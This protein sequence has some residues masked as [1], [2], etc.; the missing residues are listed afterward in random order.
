MAAL[1]L[2][3]NNTG[4]RITGSTVYVAPAS[5]NAT[6]ITVAS[7]K[8]NTIN[9]A[10][11][12]ITSGEE[13]ISL[14]SATSVLNL[15]GNVTGRPIF[16][17]AGTINFSSSGNSPLTNPRFNAAAMNQTSGSVSL[18]GSSTSGNWIGYSAGRSANYTI[19]GSGTLNL[20]GSGGAYLGV[21]RSQGANNSTLTVLTGGTVNIGTT[22]DGNLYLNQDNTGATTKLDVQGGNFTIGTGATT[23]ALVFFRAGG[24]ASKTALMTQSGGLATING[25]QFGGASGTY[26]ATALAT[27]QLS[28]GT[29]YIGT[30][31]IALGSGASALPYTNRLQGGTLAASANWSSSLNMALGTN[32]GGVTLQAA[33]SGGTARDIT[34]SGILSDDGAVNGT[35]TKTGAGT[36]TLSGAN[37]YTGDTTINAGTL[38]L[39]GGGTLANTPNLT[40]AGGATLDVSTPTTA[41]TLGGTQI[42]KVSATG[43]TTGATNIVASGKNLTLGN[44][45][46]NGLE[47]TAFA[48]G[49]APLLTL[50]GTGGNLDLNGKDIK[51][52]TTSVLGGGPYKL[53]AKSGSAT[54][55]GT[56]GALIVA[57]SGLASSGSLSVISGE[58]FLTLAVA[59]NYNITNTTASPNGTCTPAGITSV[60]SGGSQTYTITP[61]ADYT[62][63][64]LTV[65]GSPVTP[66]LSYTFNNVSANQTIQATFAPATTLYWDS[67]SSTAGF[68]STTGT[69]G[70]DPFW[71]INAGGSSPTFVSTTTTNSTVN[72]GSASLNY[73][74]PAVT[75]AG[76]GVNVGNITFG[77]GQSTALTIAGG[78]ITMRDTATITLNNASNTIGSVLAGAGTSLTK[79][80]TGNLTLT[81]ANNYAGATTISGGTLQLGAGGGV[82]R[83]TAT[84]GILNNGNLTISRSS[85]FSQATDLGAGVAITGAGSVTHAGTSTV[86]LTA[87]NSYNGTTVVNSSGATGSPVLAVSHPNALGTTAG[88]TILYGSATINNGSQLSLADTITVTDETLTLDAGPVG[89]RAT[90]VTSGTATWD[91]NVVVTGV[92]TQQIAFIANGAS[93][94]LTVGASAADTVT[95]SRNL[96]VR[97][98]GTGTVNS[99]IQIGT[100]GINKADAGTWT[101]ASTNTYTGNTSVGGGTLIIAVPSLATNSTVSVSGSGVLQLNFAETNIVA[102]FSTNNVSLPAGVYSFANM[103]PFIT[104]TGSLEILGTGP[105]GPTLTN[106][107]SGNTLT[108]TW[109]AGQALR[110]VGQTNSLSIGLNPIPSAWF[111]VPGGIDGS[112]SITINPGNPAVFYRLVS[113]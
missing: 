90:L 45:T 71:S 33:E 25:I 37:S 72:F 32:G 103:A 50:A 24:T 73:A 77:S 93:A 108:L 39:T 92:N 2:T 41:L 96:T 70:T 6:I 23:N 54:V 19:S 64:T 28:G 112:N 44:T 13:T 80:G 58:L 43:A 51:V 9:S 57:G 10:L 79:A 86:T 109:P 101:F 74:N 95:G 94:N 27:L 105:S 14:G 35:L 98:T 56:P 67:D 91:G 89:Y 15:G 52:T 110:L 11:T 104:G 5:G 83:L 66:A 4:Y 62:V 38:A 68:G 82:G 100:N 36:L 42:L 16:A 81:A 48:G 12:T 65:N 20:N 106:S 76:G 21:G 29:N 18:A 107:V 22:G 99:S 47:F 30:L 55:T 53:I 84:T 87:A 88:G 85:A 7:G 1:S 69:W 40:V 34:L 78:T 46:T 49:S 61:N 97:G 102:G 26:D 60:G 111:N 17:G 75:V 59:V 113:P 31:G 8:T 3:F 63:A